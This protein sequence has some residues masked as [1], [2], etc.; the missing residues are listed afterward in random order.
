MHMMHEAPDLDLLVLFE[1][2]Y[3]ERHLTR[4]AARVGRSQPAMSRALGRM[5]VAFGDALFVR[6][7][8]GMVP[9]PRADALAP[10]VKRVLEDARALAR[11]RAFRAADL[12]RTFVI[13][14]SDLV[15]AH[16]LSRLT[17]L[18]AR[19]APLVDVVTRAMTGTATT[20]L[21]D[22]R[23]DLV[24][25]PMPAAT[26]GVTVQHLFDDGF[27]CAVRKEHPEV[28]RKL[29]LERF[30]ALRHVLIAPRGRPG[31]NVDDALA[32]RGLKRRVAVRTQSFLAAPLLVA[33]SDFVLTAPRLILEHLAAPLGLR[34]FPPPITV[35]GFRVVSA[36]HA[37]VQE[38]PAHR[39]F[40]GLVV[41]AVRG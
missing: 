29:T 14:T 10:E 7:A 13:G 4:A 37:R 38:D 3:G 32:A 16:L 12:A 5:R 20:E 22:G 24:I 36:W 15:E 33:Q 27:L 6:T 23:L 40:R 30:L 17:A 9:T 39:W 21:A 19:E 2:L 35:P 28:R 25:A 31:G 1:A 34:T 41:R 8:S 18:V 11:P 26:E